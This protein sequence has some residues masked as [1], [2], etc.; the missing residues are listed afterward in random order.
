MEHRALGRDGPRVSVLAFGAMTFGS[1]QPPITTVDERHAQEMVDRALDA[2]VNLF[3]TADVYGNG[4]SEEILGRVLRHRRDDVLIATKTGFASHGPGALSYDNVVASCEA[5]LRR[6][7]TDRIDLY[8]LHRPDRTT[9][10]EETVRALDDLVTRGLVRDTGTSNFRAWETAGVVERQRA[11]GRRAF[12]SAQLYYSL[13]GRDAEHELLP[14][15]RSAGIGVLVWSPLAGGLLTGRYAGG[16]SSGGGAGRRSTFTFPPVDDGV[17]DRA[18]AALAPVAATHGVSVAQ[19]ALAWLLARPGVTSVL[20]GASSLAQLDDNL[21]AASLVLS[22]G[23]LAALDD[24]TA[25]APVYP[26]WWDPAMRIPTPEDVA[27][28]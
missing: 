24:A 16:D 10:L 14:H 27:G 9:P 8:Q 26:A 4:T 23:E 2:G 15:C 3:D 22:P 18:L 5:S 11:L 6:L 1:G 12:T 17:A 20:V 13:V 28:D 21:A 25:P 7:G 19:V